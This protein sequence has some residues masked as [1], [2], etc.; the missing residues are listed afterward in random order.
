MKKVLFLLIS[1]CLLVGMPSC[2]KAMKKMLDGVSQTV[3]ADGK[4]DIADVQTLND[5]KEMLLSKC[6]TE[7]MPIMEINIIE[8]EECTGRTG[9]AIVY[10]T[11]ADKTQTY[12][13]RFT[14]DGTV[15]DLRDWSSS[16]SNA[17]PIDLKALD[18]NMIVKGIED[19]KSTIPEGY[20]FK[21]V[22]H[23]FIKDGVSKLLL[24]LTK[25]GEETIS[26]AGKTSEVYYKAN[27]DIDNATGK[28]TDMN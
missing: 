21:A 26:N 8:D 12:Q 19:A 18:M 9:D 15:G 14:L 16:K 7:K 6:D 25:D 17:K 5:I 27:Y 22:Q 20:T 4:K 10:L 2:K 28:A 3:G 13:Q 23:I 1:A 24:A 11:D